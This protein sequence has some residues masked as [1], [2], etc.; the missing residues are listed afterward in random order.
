MFSSQNPTNT[1]SAKIAVMIVIARKLLGAI[2]LAVRWIVDFA[3]KAGFFMAR[4]TL[5]QQ[6]VVNAFSFFDLISLRKVGM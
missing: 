6:D 3:W 4:I 1:N 5:I 2:S